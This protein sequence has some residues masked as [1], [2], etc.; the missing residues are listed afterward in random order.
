MI[1]YTSTAVDG[2]Q[3]VGGRDKD[4][5]RKGPHV[6]ELMS[7]DCGHWIE[8]TRHWLLWRHVPEPVNPVVCVVVRYDR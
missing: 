8:I 1:P 5:A 6:D 3:L 2:H 7:T 4:A